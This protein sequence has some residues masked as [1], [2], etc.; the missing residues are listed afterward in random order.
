MD[1]A[2]LRVLIDEVVD[3]VL[4]KVRVPQFVPGTVTDGTDV[5]SVWVIIDGDT[6]P[7]LAQ[8]IIGPIAA[9]QRVM[10]CFNPPSGALVLGFIGEWLGP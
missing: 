2:S 1:Q 8:S 7:V 5:R 9:G 3:R 6:D 10:V 4:Q